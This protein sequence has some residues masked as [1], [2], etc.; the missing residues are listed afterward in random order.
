VLVKHPLRLRLSGDAG[1]RNFGLG[2]MATNIAN[3]AIENLDR[4]V[5]GRFW[6]TTSLGEYTAA[7]N[8]SR[9]PTSM[10]VG[11]AQ[12]VVFASASRMQDDSAR[13][14]RSFTA[15]ACL[16]LLLAC[17]VFCFLALEAPLVIG[18]LY[19]QQWLGAAPLFAAMCV[20]VPSY[21]LLSVAGPTLWAVGAVRSELKVQLVVV[22][23]ML[24]GLFLLSGWPLALAVWWVPAIY[25]VRALAR[26]VAHA[27]SGGLL[28]TVVVLAVD[29]ATQQAPVAPLASAALSASTATALC[30]GVLHLTSRWVLA[31]DLRQ[32]L[33]NR[34]AGGSRLFTGLC[35]AL[36][37][38]PT[39]P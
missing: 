34:S 36:G 22:V 5:V 24:G 6:G 7:V 21:A 39:A 27:A 33:L 23:L 4:V 38:R 37:L 13:V 8:L 28:L 9:A 25:A 14:A 3:W 11:A 10:V 2:V 32:I 31:P 26:R 12:A 29:Q 17:P 20:A 16:V 1:L 18:L 15:A 35:A 30:L 19:G